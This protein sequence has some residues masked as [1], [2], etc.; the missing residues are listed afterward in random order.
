[1]R[2][3]TRRWLLPDD[4]PSSAVPPLLQRILLARGLT[5]PLAVRRFC[6]PRL[7]DLHPPERLPGLEAAAT[8]LVEAVR[9]GRAITIY[10]DY[11]VDGITATAIL[12]HV[13]ATA[14]PEADL[15]SYVPHRL[16]EGY[17]LNGDALREIR[18]AGSDVCISVD[19]GI[20]AVE[21][22]R[23]AR[24]IGLELVITDH[25]NLPEDGRLPDA[26]AVVH[27]RLP[28]GDYPFGELCGA[29]VA[30]KLAWRFATMWCGSER[31]SESLQQMLL[32][33]LPLVALGTIADVAPL[34]D[35]NRILTR[36]GLDMIRRTPLPG[37]RA[38]LEASELMDETIDTQKV[39]FR[40]APR[41]NASGRMGHAREAVRL[42]TTA[43]PAEAASIARSLCDLNR[44]RQATERNIVEQACR[45]AED[46][47]M[48]RDDCRAIVLA[49]PGWHPGVIGIV[50]S[51]LV[52]RFGRP[53]V[54]LQRTGDLCKG[55]ARS[56]DGYSIHDALVSCAEHLE[57]F[58][59]HDAA[60]GLCV[61]ANR[62][63]AFTDA[64]VA[65][66][67]AHIEHEQLTPSI[68]IDCDA[69]LGELRFE[70]V[71]Q[72]RDLSP[73]GRGNRSPTLRVKRAIVAE[74]PRQIGG[75][76]RHLSLRVR[77]DGPG[78]RRV[79]R[80]VWWGAGHLAGDLAAGLPV[81][82]AIEPKINTWNGRSNVEAE[83]R[84]VVLLSA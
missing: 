22:A 1:M 51:R 75:Q 13:V 46:R 84:D 19:C 82:I 33:M 40:L 28:G 74:P 6:Q 37:L 81:D 79:L 18:A 59:G 7:T 68:R 24:A 50:A 31:V 62:L 52:E 77:Q 38:L 36:H 11:D 34:V 47:G 20:T 2:G 65:H 9:A 80:A 41:L 32:S 73:F 44:E 45:L 63:D 5:D 35:E 66:A 69:S 23:I 55:S 16:E 26:A 15:R 48:I 14:C 78:G 3:L 64:L 25:H 53:A 70:T 61:R 12:H 27:P 39:G 8:R 71:E 56:I 58:G 49:D 57:S 83:I 4:A 42:L 10:G 54:L 72:I 43:P 17:G 67:N 21:P 29:G 60:A 30:F 76:G